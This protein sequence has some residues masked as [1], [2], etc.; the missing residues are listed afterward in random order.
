[1]RQLGML[2]IVLLISINAQA[3][4]FQGKAV[5]ESKT[6]ID[7]DFSGM[8]VPED[9]KQEMMERM[10]KAGERTFILDF[11]ATESIYKEE[12][13]LEQ[14]GARGGRGRRF[15]MLMGDSSDLYKNTK[16]GTYKSKKDLYGK[17]FLVEDNLYNYEWK[18]T[19]ETRKIGNYTA[20]KATATKLIKRPN[21]KALF[22][23]GDDKKEKKEVFIEKEVE[24]VVWYTP[25]IPVSNGPQDYYGLPGLILEVSDDTTTIL[26]SKIVLNAKEK[27]AI[28]AP[29]KGKK[30]S[31][32]EFDEIS[33]KK[34]KEMR[35]VFR[36]RRGRG[37]NR[38]G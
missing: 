31:Q 24:V 14:P 29:R 23:R 6:Q 8:K 15:G 1:M 35:E 18:M 19:A 10:K 25:E 28:A 37:G 34:T 2:F 36:N 4:T 3:Q 7:F 20:Y 9:R 13:K 32:K 22:S 27:V 11:N 5:Y 12:E 30:V 17:I 33:Q 26:C 16:E 21:I 38:R